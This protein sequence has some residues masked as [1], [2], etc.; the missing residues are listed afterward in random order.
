MYACAFDQTYT[1]I[2]NT[3]CCVQATNTIYCVTYAL[4]LHPYHTLTATDRMYVIDC[5]SRVRINCIPLPEIVLLLR[6]TAH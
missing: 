5:M 4:L 1:C 2:N 3:R 6:Y